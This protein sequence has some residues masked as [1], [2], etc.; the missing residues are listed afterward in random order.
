[1]F[2]GF[3]VIYSTAKNIQI[4]SVTYRPIKLLRKNIYIILLP[5]T[6]THKTVEKFKYLHF[7][8]FKTRIDNIEKFF[9]SKN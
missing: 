2:I 5:I 9:A 3:K 8:L 7:K 4:I 1:M 6:V